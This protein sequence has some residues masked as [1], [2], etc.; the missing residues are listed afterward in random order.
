MSQENPNATATDTS[1][2]SRRDNDDDFINLGEIVGVLLDYKWL[3]MLVTTFAVAIGVAVALISTPIYRADAL[4]QIEDKSS[5]KGALAALRDVE[6]ALGDSTSVAAE[7]EILRSR[8]IL[9]RVVDRLDL[10]VR[11]NAMRAPIVGE[12]FARRHGGTE[13]AEPPFGQNWLAQY[14]WG[15]E[16]I[17]VERFEVPNAWLGLNFTL[18]VQEGGSYILFDETGAQRFSG[19]VGQ[20]AGD[21]TISLFVSELVARPGTAFA[22]S[23]ISREAA[24][25]SLRERFE[26]RER[27]GSRV[28]GSGVVEMALTGPQRDM[29]SVEL[30]EIVTAYVRQ[31]VEYRS[32]EAEKTLEFLELQLPVLKAQLD[33]AEAAYNE[34]RQTRGSVDL[35]LETQSVLRSIVDVDNEIVGLQQKR[36][37][38]RQRFTSEHPQVVALDR[39]INRLNT[40]RATLEGSV[41]QLPETQKV[42][43]RLSRDVE[44]ATALYT[45]LL[46]SAQQLRV[47]RAGTVGDVRV[48]DPAVTAIHPIAPRKPLIVLLAGVLGGLVSLGI[49]WAIRA[50]RVV[51]EDPQSIERDLALPVYATVPFSKQEETLARKLSRGRVKA[52]QLLAISQPEEDAIEALRSLRTTL[53]FALLGADR[54]SVLLT[55]PA[56]GVGKSFIT[57]NLGAVLAQAGKRVIIVDADLRK[58][59]IHKDFGLKRDGGLSDFIMGRA[60]LESILHSTPQPG[61]RLITTGQVPPNPSELLM[62]PRFGELLT[63]LQNQCDVLLIDAPPVLAVSD[64]AIIGRHTGAALMVARA[65]RHPIRELEQAVKRLGQGGVSVKGFVF[66]GFDLTRQRARFG[67]EGYHYSYKYSKA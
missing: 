2:S 49:V 11:A 58:G 52:G 50:T 36:E 43:L 41:E 27:G 48:I 28:R 62:H 20:V 55:G 29:L 18:Y 9:G 60:S 67:Y 17:K 16:R 37:E 19:R 6:A 39:Q 7:L 31:N 45:S 22:L 53:H 26:A 5:S 3:I 1:F 51:V 61:L 65:G 64:A 33:D 23:R 35:T 25:A 12:A 66:N 4:V 14:A 57:K 15:G 32:A 59:H 46:N 30:N 44:V 56:P 24:I 38:L 34:Y 54:N 13:P 10:T 21:E 47:A 40:R 8:M 42:A 63:A